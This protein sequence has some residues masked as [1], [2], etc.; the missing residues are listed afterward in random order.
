MLRLEAVPTRFR[1]GSRLRE[2]RFEDYDEIARLESRF[3]LAVK[4]YDEWVHLWQ[5]NPL[6]REF[7]GEWPIGWVL[8]DEDRKIAGSMGNI[9]LS[10]ELDGRRI[11]AATG[12]HWVAETQHRSASILLLHSLITQRRIDLYVNTT[13]SSAAVPAV[14]ALGCS[15]V[16][17]GVWDEARYWITNYPGLFGC[18]ISRKNALS[19]Y[20]WDRSWR[21]LKA[22][23]PRLANFLRH[24][25]SNASLKNSEGESALRAR[26]VEVTECADFDHR[27]DAFW[28]ELS[29]NHRHTLVTVR[30]QEFLNWHF[31]YALRENRLWIATIVDGSRVTAYAIFCKTSAARTPIKQVKLVDY[32]SLD[33]STSMLEVF[34]AW[35]LKKCRSEGIHILEHTGRWLRENEFFQKAAPYKRTLPAW[36]Y[37]YRINNPALTSALSDP[38][39]WAPFLYDGDATL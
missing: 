7:R 31:K 33:G 20:S 9:P 14:T 27:F 21:H 13:V 26:D 6:Y 38:Q 30:S 15:R 23:G 22:T 19:T 2:A 10:Y 34:V 5:G 25:L 3:D 29:R 37:F 39:V 32:Q 35:A 24:R 12:R 8:E 4:P 17:V 18:L 16:P 36:Q 1:S 28:E 11:V